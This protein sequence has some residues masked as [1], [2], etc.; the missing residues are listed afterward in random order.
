[1]E[2]EATKKPWSSPQVMEIDIKMTQLGGGYGNF[3]LFD[4]EEEIDVGS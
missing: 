1:M 2:K 3:D 4:Q